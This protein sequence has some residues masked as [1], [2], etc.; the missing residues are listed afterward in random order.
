MLGLFF[1]G[2]AGDIL[3]K[4]DIA[5]NPTDFK[6]SLRFILSPLIAY[7]KVYIPGFFVLISMTLRSIRFIFLQ[8]ITSLIN[9]SSPAAS[10]IDNLMRIG[11]FSLHSKTGF[12]GQSLITFR[13]RTI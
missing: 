10:D 12:V 8:Y 4:T 2:F 6:K 7:L 9:A 5:I 1:C 3:E 11:G 13:G